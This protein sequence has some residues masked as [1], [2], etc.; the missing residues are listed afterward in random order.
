MVSSSSRDPPYIQLIQEVGLDDMSY[1]GRSFA[2]SSNVCG[3]GIRRS[4]LDKALTNAEWVLHF[5][6]A[7]LIHLPQ[8]GSD[9]RPIIWTL[10]I[11]MVNGS[12]AY[13]LSRR[14]I[15]ARRYIT[16]WNRENFGDIQSNIFLLHQ[17]IAAIQ[18]GIQDN[19][20]T[21][22]VQELETQIKYWHQVQSEFWGQNARADYYLEM[23]RNTKHHHVMANKR[24]SRNNIMAL[25]DA[26]GH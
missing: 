18:E 7:K 26:D 4:R 14:L 1:T 23:D 3:G 25:K 24:R 8:L 5:P 13:K 9:H 12:D 16:R 11:M 20:S 15:I 10:H 19:N 2:W 22:H 6:D 21:S 17:Q